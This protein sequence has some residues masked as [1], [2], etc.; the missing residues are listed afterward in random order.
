[1]RDPYKTRQKEL[2]KHSIKNCKNEFTIKE[3]FTKLNEKDQT[4]GLTTIYRVANKLVKAGALS[5]KLVFSFNFLGKFHT[6]C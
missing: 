6:C 5:K 3:L 4:L 1:M 2:I